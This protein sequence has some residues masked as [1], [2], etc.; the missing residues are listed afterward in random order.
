MLRKVERWQN[1]TSCPFSLVYN[2]GFKPSELKM[3]ETILEDNEE[4]IAQH[5]NLFI[6]R[7]VFIS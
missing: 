4:M 7:I 3:T 2:H 6:D 5:W 1:I